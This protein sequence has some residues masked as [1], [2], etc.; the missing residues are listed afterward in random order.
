LWE[1]DFFE[2]CAPSDRLVSV[3]DDQFDL[4]V[5]NPPFESKFTAAAQRINKARVAERGEIPD[6]Q[7]AYLFLDQGLQ[8]LTPNGRLCLIQ[9]SSFLYN[10]QS[11]AFRGFVAATGRLEAIFDFTSVRGLYES[12]DPKTVAV[13]V[14]GERASR[15]THLTF[16]RTYKTAQR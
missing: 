6:K 7:V 14:G 5:G 15:F 4:V 11:H 8:M 9:P 12:A 3:L 16:R 2:V 10:L 13:L 1:D